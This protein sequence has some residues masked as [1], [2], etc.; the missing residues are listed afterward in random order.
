MLPWLLPLLERHAEEAAERSDAAT[1]YLG[2][3]EAER[4]AAEALAAGDL[5]PEAYVRERATALALPPGV[6]YVAGFTAD[7]PRV[8]E[9]GR[10][11]VARGLRLSRAGF[12]G[13]PGEDTPSTRFAATTGLHVTLQVQGACA[14]LP[15]GATVLAI[16]APPSREQLLR[17]MNGEAHA[18]ALEGR[19]RA[20]RLT[21]EQWDALVG[22]LG[23][24]AMLYAK[25]AQGFDD[26][27]NDNVAWY[28]HHAARLDPLMACVLRDGQPD[29][30]PVPRRRCTNWQGIAHDC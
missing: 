3:A 28:A 18:A 19:L 20:A 25:G 13:R 23:G 9:A 11:F 24:A 1:A 12:F 8:R 5:D 15:T 29:D 16:V 22:A 26:V 14:T 7:E 27:T 21:R 2:G 17:V 30:S 10:F 6:R 4:R